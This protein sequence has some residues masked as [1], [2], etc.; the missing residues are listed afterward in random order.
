MHSICI[1]DKNIDNKNKSI[2]E[3]NNKNNCFQCCLKK[4][5]NKIYPFYD[6][7]DDFVN[8]KIYHYNTT[9]FLKYYNNKK[10]YK[11][12][13]IDIKDINSFDIYIKD[14]ILNFITECITK[15]LEERCN[16]SKI[17]S[18]SNNLTIFVL[19]KIY[20]VYEIYETNKKLNT[21]TE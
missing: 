17:N 10:Y 6:F 5:E 21:I 12:I 18:I 1:N 19:E 7:I 8:I 4:K 15:I 3:N 16:I 14:V 20:E 13:D 9:T 2:D 11:I